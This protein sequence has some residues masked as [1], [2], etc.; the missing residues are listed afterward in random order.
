MSIEHGF[1][2]LTPEGREKG[3]QHIQKEKPDLIIGEW[4]CGPFSAMQ[5]IN[6]TRSPEL[7]DRILEAQR[8]HTKVSAWIAKVEKW[9]RTVNRGHWLGEQPAQCRSW[10]SDCL[11]E[12]QQENLNTYLD[13][14]AEDLKDPQIGLPY[15]KRTKLN[16]TSGILHHL[17]E[18]PPPMPW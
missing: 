15:R 17:I 13:M 16:C 10:K 18:N 5:N 14:C 6:L 8:Q 4:M 1:N 12:M 2:I 7:R 3:W 9:Q 11:Q